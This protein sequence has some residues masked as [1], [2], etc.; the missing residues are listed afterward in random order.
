[1]LQGG[2]DLSLPALEGL[3]RRRARACATGSTSPS[4]ASARA[5]ASAAPIAATPRSRRCSPATSTGATLFGGPG[6]GARWFHTGGIFCALGEGTPAVARA[7]ME[8][9]RRNGTCVSYD[10]NYRDSL[11]RSFGGKDAG[12]RRSTASLMPFVDVLFGN[13]EDFSAALG[14]ELE[15]VDPSFH[16][17][18][19]REL[20]HDDRARCRRVPQHHHR[21]HDAAHGAL[22]ERQRLGRDLLPRGAVLRGP[23]ARRRD[24][25]PRRRRRLV[26]LGAHLRPARRAR[27]RSGR[28]SAA[29]PTARWRCRRPAT[30]PWRRSPR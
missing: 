9:A 15:G 26:R 24:P 3:R 7:A 25:G 14:F 29:S 20:P 13:E 22:G 19:D 11:W 4:A 6:Q 30:P 21:R 2:V 5:A 16:D 17:A 23:A 10:L 28:S 27:T 8:E 18:A 12:A 1:M